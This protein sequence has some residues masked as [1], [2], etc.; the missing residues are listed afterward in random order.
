MRT[1]DNLVQLQQELRASDQTAD[2]AMLRALLVFLAVCLT[3]AGL[4]VVLLDDPSPA[5]VA[6]AVFPALGFNLWLLDQSRKRRERIFEKH[7]FK[8][9]SCGKTPSSLRLLELTS[10][11]FC[12]F[13][14]LKYAP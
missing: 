2:K 4:L 3:I 5:V 14:Q 13:C 11:S 6:V 12:P 10:K 1:P 9:Q 7:G 8:C